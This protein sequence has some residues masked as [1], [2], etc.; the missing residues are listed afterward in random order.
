MADY[1]L[2]VS[3]SGVDA[4]KLG[5]STASRNKLPI[6]MRSPMAKLDTTN[7]VSFQNILLTFT[8]DPPEPTGAGEEKVTAVY[9]FSHGYS[10][11]PTVWALAQVIQR[12]NSP[13]NYY[14]NFFQAVGIL[15]TGSSFDFAALQF[16][17][18]QNKVYLNIRKYYDAGAGGGTNNLIGCQVL[19]RVYVFTE[20]YNNE[21]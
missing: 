19:V 7:V 8:T 9:E 10:Y 5:T 14:Q 18:D 2:R 13:G 11:A 20:D 12:P 1:G 3:E 6:N 17:N 16:N 21:P 15:R 4:T